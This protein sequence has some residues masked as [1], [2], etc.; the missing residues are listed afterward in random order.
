MLSI[1]GHGPS[2]GA[3][4]TQAGEAYLAKVEGPEPPTPRQANVSVT[5][6]LVDRVIA[7]GGML[8]VPSKDWRNRDSVDYMR[9]ARLA[10]QHGK[11]PVGKL[12]A[13]K[14]LP[15]GDLQIELVSGPVL[16]GRDEEQTPIEV[17]GKISRYHPAAKA[18]RDGKERHEVSRELV[19]RATRIVHVIAR[20]AEARGWEAR[21]PAPSKN[22]YGRESWTASKNG[23]L[24]VST[25]SEL[26]WFRIRESKVHVRGP[27]EEEVERHRGADPDSY[28]WRDREIPRGAYD[29][30]A[31]GKL[32]LELFCGH[33]YAF[34][35]RQSRWGDRQRWSLE[36][37]LTD[38]VVEIEIRAVEATLREEQ[39]R[40]SAIRA[41][42]EAEEAARQRE[43][44]FEL[45]LEEAWRLLREARQAKEL[46]TQTSAWSEANA[47][48]AYCDAVE[49]THGDNPESRRWLEW[50]RGFIERLDPL[51][52]PPSLPE[53]TEAP[54]DELQQYMPEGWSVRGAEYP[55]PRRVGGGLGGRA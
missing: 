49:D 19:P 22:A 20:E 12:L 32:E 43:V 13:I 15:D 30:D 42:Q 47:L 8:V 54:Y 28:W 16:P 7:G 55:D 33:S 31:D 17:P 27:W 40:E 18:F 35:G 4:L 34:G 37:R 26:F 41:K 39:K 3:N 29:A 21:A 46:R 2:W 44:D 51:D 14:N 6:E 23:H 5:Q 11:V 24:A 9:R 36:D 38:A 50:A 48:R 10:E 52:K 45:H 1:S 25:E 53:I